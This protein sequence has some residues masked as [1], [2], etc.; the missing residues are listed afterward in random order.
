MY[1][2]KAGHASSRRERGCASVRG[3][4]LPAPLPAS[5]RRAGYTRAT[6]HSGIT[7]LGKLAF[8]FFP[9]ILFFAV[10]KLHEDQTQGIIT[11][12]AVAIAGSIAQVL[13]GH[14]KHGKVETMHWVLMAMVIVLGGLTIIFRDETFIKWK[15]SVV[16]WLFAAVFLG[17]QFFGNKNLSRRM[18]EKA[19]PVAD[20][21]WLWVNWSWIIFFIAIGAL[22]LYVAYSYD[23]DTWVNFKLFGML[24]L[25]FVFVI[26]QTLVLMRFMEQTPAKEPEDG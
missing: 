21:V 22:N 14:I 16:N 6:T 4:A 24:G 1:A 15:P 26:G 17:S 19:I 7:P 3:E 12:T 8:D 5:A 23:L 18:L 11:A 9:V 25:T 13:Y 2:Q 20:A 10:Y